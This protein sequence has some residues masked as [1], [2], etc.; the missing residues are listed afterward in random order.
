MATANTNTAQP[1]YLQLISKDEK[2]I[3]K[4]GLAIKAQEASIE[5][6]RDIMDLN[7]Q[8]ASK[9]SQLV[10]AQ[11]QIPYSVKREFKLEVELMKLEEALDFATSIKKTRFSDVTI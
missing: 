4:E 3:A 5:V 7:A 10:A 8:I 1:T 2:V 11:R 6:Q 9:K